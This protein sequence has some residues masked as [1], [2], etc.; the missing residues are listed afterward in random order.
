MVV[1]IFL[2]KVAKEEG[3]ELAGVLLKRSLEEE[4]PSD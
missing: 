4:E 1:Y 3:A 2:P